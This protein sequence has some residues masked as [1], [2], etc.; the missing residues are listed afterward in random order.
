MV[1]SSERDETTLDPALLASVYLSA[2]ERVIQ[3]GFEDE[4]DWQEEVSLDDVDEHTFL[5]ECA[6][7]VLSAGFREAILRRCFQ[8]ISKAFLEWE[9]ANLIIRQ[10]DLCRVNALEVFGNRRKIDA[11][12]L[13]AEQVATEGIVAIREQIACQG[14]E[15]L[16]QLPF[17]GPVTACHL[18][19]NL[20]VP[21]VKPDRHLMRMA[22]KTGY[23]SPEQMCRTIAE[24]VGDPLPVIDIV[25]WRN[26][27]LTDKH[28]RNVYP[29]SRQ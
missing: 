5:R 20:G 4:I 12:L 9:S 16:R 29:R 21:I 2:K 6:W 8:D 24:I 17:I 3:A 28:E 11:I 18:A 1:D 15:F 10:R 25:I 13:V 27:T 22:A 23:E 26:A 14:T 19:K 7:V